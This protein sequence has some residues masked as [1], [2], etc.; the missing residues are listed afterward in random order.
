MAWSIHIGPVKAC[1]D[2]DNGATDLHGD[3]CWYYNN[4]PRRCGEYDDD[5]F[6]ASKICCACKKGKKRPC[7]IK[8]WYLIIFIINFHHKCIFH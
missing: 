3:G 2:T 4:Y 7:K 8:D 1:D 6:V 5:D